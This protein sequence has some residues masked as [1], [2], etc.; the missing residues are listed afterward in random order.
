M[1]QKFIGPLIQRLKHWLCDGQLG[2]VMEKNWAHSVNQCQ[3][4]ALQFLVHLINLL[5]IHL[6]YNGF[7]EIQRVVVDQTGSRPP[8]SD[9]DLFL[10]KFGF[11]KCLKLLFAPITELVITSCHIKFTFHGTPQSD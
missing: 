8:N 11:G 7:T 1:R 3:L 10:C 5:S 9:H 6:R 4:Q 2:V